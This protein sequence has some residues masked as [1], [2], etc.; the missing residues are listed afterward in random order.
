MAGL[1]NPVRV[2][3]LVN[4]DHAALNF[5]AYRVNWINA[6]T[7]F[8]NDV[9]CGLGPHLSRLGLR[10][11]RV[12]A[13]DIPR[14]AS[15]AGI[16]RLLLALVRHLRARRYAIV[17]THNSITG[18]VG[19]LAARLARVPVVIHTIHGFHFHEHMSALRRL[20]FVAAERRLARLS[21]VL[22]CQNRE[23]LAEVARL[24]VCPRQGVFHVSNGIDLR[25]F[26]PRPAPPRNARPVILCV[27][28]LEAV[29]NQAMLLRALVS[30]RRRHDP[31]VW[32]VGDGPFRERYEAMVRR[33]GLADTVRFLGYRYDLPELTAAADVAVLTSLKEG[34]PRAL[35]EAMAVGVPVVAT[36]VKGSREVVVDGHTGFLVPLD[37]VDGLGERLAEL[38]GSPVLRWAM[39]ARGVAH[40]RQHF[41]EERIVK[42]L[43]GLYRLAL[44][45]RG[46]SPG[47]D[48]Q[49]GPAEA[50]G[51][52]ASE[53]W[54]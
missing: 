37:D 38:L 22:L 19:R 48:A 14:G 26:R 36:D 7:E 32:L 39:G 51:L 54:R 30:L 13:L 40:A 16:T 52:R 43:A 12:T 27:G 31:E 3:D 5:L 47:E 8:E 17:H 41:D 25:R 29:K 4:T 24:G 11:A 9:V 49:E 46:V 35:M 34:L 33:L 53:G 28:R 6:H 18:A 23:D 10:G 15:P 42:R 44:R 21:D 1:T 50:D 20:P 45:T 2:L